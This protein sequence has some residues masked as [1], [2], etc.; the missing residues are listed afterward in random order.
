MELIQM[1]GGPNISTVDNEGTETW[2]YERSVSQT[3]VAARSQNW[4]AAANLGVAFGH[5]QGG[6]SG[7]GGQSGSASST[8]SSFRSLTVIVKFNADKTV[9][10]YSVR[11]SQF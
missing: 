9:K 5:A 2:I 11:S 8:A 1:F 10:D 3:D 4:Q 7:G 6:V